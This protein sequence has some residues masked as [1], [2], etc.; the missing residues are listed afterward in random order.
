MVMSIIIMV[1]FYYD[2]RF[3][4]VQLLVKKALHVL[5]CNL[6]LGITVRIKTFIFFKN[7]KNVIRIFVEDLYLKQ[8]YSILCKFI[9]H[10]ET[11][12]PLLPKK[13]IV[14]LHTKIKKKKRHQKRALEGTGCQCSAEEGY[15]LSYHHLQLMCVVKQLSCVNFLFLYIKY[16]HW[17]CSERYTG[18]KVS[19]DVCCS[20]YDGAQTT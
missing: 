11:K 5:Q 7:I 18:V 12:S 20:T 9:L 3:N 2:V 15:T 1:L 8:I 14:C 4:D 6:T 17:V 16:N 13:W 19:I 10:K